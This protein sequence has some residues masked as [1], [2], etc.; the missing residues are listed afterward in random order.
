ML[1]EMPAL[2]ALHTGFIPA[3]LL[4]AVLLIGIASALMFTVN[5]SSGGTDIA[6]MILAFKKPGLPVGRALLI[7]DCVIVA[8]TCFLLGWRAGIT[9]IIGLAIKCTLIDLFMKFLAKKIK[10]E[11]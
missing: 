9:S 1:G 2:V 3:D 8:A 7:T 10:K 6:A 4:I 11:A 5:G